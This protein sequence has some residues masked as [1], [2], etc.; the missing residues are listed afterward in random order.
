MLK[1]NGVS[2]GKRSIYITS[3]RQLINTIYTHDM[4]I[5]GFPARMWTV[6]G[7]RS[8]PQSLETMLIKFAFY[9]RFSTY[10]NWLVWVA[11]WKKA[12]QLLDQQ[13]R[14]L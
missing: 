14:R 2:I 1:M 8:E 11:D 12:Q 13:L 9:A 10:T 3:R 5:D 6:R 7:C 4:H